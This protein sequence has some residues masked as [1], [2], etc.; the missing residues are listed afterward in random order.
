MNE[1]EPKSE[2]DYA[3]ELKERQRLFGSDSDRKLS[4]GPNYT[5][6]QTD[7]PGQYILEYP[8]GRRVLVEIE[9]VTGK[10]YFLREL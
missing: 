3:R 2:A 5:R 8:G 6:H 1:P 7:E 4:S 10:E 9:L